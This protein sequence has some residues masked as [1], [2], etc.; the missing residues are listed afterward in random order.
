ML[1]DCDCR[2]GGEHDAADGEQAFF[3][4][5][6]SAGLDSGEWAVRGVKSLDI[7]IERGGEDPIEYPDDAV[8]CC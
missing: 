2:R 5:L 7:R 6:S 4:T 1:L 3:E 8:I